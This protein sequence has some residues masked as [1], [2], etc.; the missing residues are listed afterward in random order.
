M[1]MHWRGPTRGNGI[2]VD[3]QSQHLIDLTSS[4]QVML[5][6]QLHENVVQGHLVTLGTRAKNQMEQQYC[7]LLA[8]IGVYG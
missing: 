2:P 6:C 7:M 4:C 8:L 1:Q 3:N 5:S